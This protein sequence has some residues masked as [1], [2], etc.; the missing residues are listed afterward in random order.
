MSRIERIRFFKTVRPLR[1]LFR[2]SLG[3]KSAATSVLVEVTLAGGAKGTGEVPTSF[4]LP[5]ETPEAIKAVL[6]DARLALTGS[7]IDDYPAHLAALRKRFPA[8]HMTLS[9]LEVALFRAALAARGESEFAHWSG[10]SRNVET[11]VTVAFMPDGQALSRWMKHTTRIGFRH[12]KVKVTGNVEADIAFVKAVREHLE[13]LAEGYVIRLDGNQGYKADTYRRMLDALGRAKIDIE[14][15]EQPLAAADFAGL[16]KIAGCS[17]MPVILDETVFDADACRRVGDERL[18]DGVNIKVAKS[19]IAGSAAILKC[20]RAAGLRLMIGC[21]T[22]T[23]VGL[24]AG[25]YMAAGTAAFDYVDLDAAHLLFSARRHGDIAIA[26]RRYL[27]GESAR[28]RIGG[29]R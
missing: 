26:G 7:P 24:S 13:R 14:L 16:R 18:G 23:M 2:T 1:T 17:P 11:D 27:I 20:A 8:F 25:I 28:V 4:V 29:K 10:R 15:F 19:G 6:A 9:G 21:M 12:Y 5:H 22:E 3:S